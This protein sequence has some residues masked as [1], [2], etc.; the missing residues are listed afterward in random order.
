MTLAI[1]VEAGHARDHA[2]VV[3]GP[4]VTERWQ[5]IAPVTPIHRRAAAAPDRGTQGRVWSA[6]VDG[7]TGVRCHPTR[8]DVRP[9]G[10]WQERLGR[11]GHQTVL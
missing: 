7:R 5:S 3:D 11:S 1:T 2:A 6:V 4:V 10:S 9:R 8:L